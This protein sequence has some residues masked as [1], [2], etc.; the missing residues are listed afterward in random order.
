[1]NRHCLI[2]GAVAVAVTATTPFKPLAAQE[3]DLVFWGIEFEQL[4]YRFGDTGE[5]LL[6]WDGDAFAGTD[7]LKLRWRGEGE[8]DLDADEAERLENQILLQKPI[9]DFFDIKGGVRL[10]TP[11]GPDRWYGVLGVAGLAQQWF[12]VDADMFVSETGDVSARLE[13]EYEALLTNRLILTPS[14]ELDAA[15]GADREIGV[16][17]GFSS[18]EA[19]ARLSYDLLDRAIAPY[20][21]VSYER[22]LFDTADFAREDGED[23]QAW[24]GVVGVRL[25]Y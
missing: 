24:Y 17:G 14:I 2:A 11:H 15:S 21:G 3:T 19:G 20:V 16:G 10:D 12:E 18:I 1:M 8:Y 25:S 7:E 5:D 4:E 13:V 6:A 22:K 9:S 23:T